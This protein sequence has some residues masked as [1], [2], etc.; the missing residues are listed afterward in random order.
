MSVPIY[1]PVSQKLLP[2]DNRPLPPSLKVQKEVDTQC[3]LCTCQPACMQPLATIGIFTGFYSFANMLAQTLNYYV[4]SQI[5]TLER[6][7][8]FSSYYTGIIMAANDIGFLVCVLFAAH[9]ATKVHVA[10][11]LG[12]TMILFGISGISCSLPHFL[13]GAS[14]NKD[15][16]TDNSNST[17]SNFS[18]QPFVGSFCDMFNISGDPCGIDAALN[19]AEQ[20][21]GTASEKVSQI[22]F[23]IIVLGMCL[24]GFGKAPNT[25]YAL[26]YVDDNTK[27]VNTGFYI[28]IIAATSVLGPVSAFL[29]GGVFSRIYVTL[30]VTQLTPRHPRWIGAWWLGFVVFGLLAVI[31]AIP[32]FC[33]PRKLPRSKVKDARGNDTTS[34]GNVD[35]S[36]P[37]LSHDSLK[38]RHGD[39]IANC[40]TAPSSKRLGFRSLIKHYRE[41]IASLCRLLVNPIYVCWVVSS[42]FY[43]F[44]IA[45]STAF[46]PKYLERVFDLEVHTANYIT[47]ATFM[48]ASFGGV[49]VGGFLSRRYKMTAMRCLQFSCLMTALSVM[50]STHDPHLS[51][52][53]CNRGCNCRDNSYFPICGDDGKTYYSPCH[54]GCL[55]AEHGIYQNCSCVLSGQAVTGVCEFGCSHLYGYVISGCLR[56]LS[57]ALNFVP[58]TIVFMRCVPEQD[59]SMSLSVMP[60]VNSLF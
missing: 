57:M 19:T 52:N 7:F 47:A 44:M 22:S 32:L 15:P 46:Y 53:S 51:E 21:A 4:N 59:R 14:V 5:T 28:G 40:H 11:S 6:Q 36:K 2:L 37:V 30:E 10:R 39:K 29:L 27:K 9:L 13:F 17:E 50:I 1:K 20:K 26:V 35:L 3:G 18:K 8:G 54:A 55:L 58:K 12:V 49:F 31:A 34:A 24:Q 23:L 25:S 48:S 60:F 43:I 56:L 42:C 33:F 38:Q 16:T 41:F 45:G